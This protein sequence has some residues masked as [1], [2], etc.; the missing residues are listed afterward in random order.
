M[1]T[2]IAGIIAGVILF[3]WGFL[4]W[5]VLPIHKSSLRSLS[6][7]DAV[8]AALR[9]SSPVKGLYL[10]PAMPTDNTPAA[11]DAYIQKYK[12]GPTGIIIYDPDGSSPM[13]TGQMIIGFINSI[14]TGLLGAWLLSRSTAVS[15]SYIARVALFGVIGVLISLATHIVNWNW[16]NYPYDY[17]VGLVIDSVIGWLLAGLGAAAFLKTP[18]P[19]TVQ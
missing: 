6:N 2:I 1:K 14:L 9:A 18:S 19:S 3:I 17:T 8:I 12:A 15:S 16:L 10:F 4:A 5:A 7:E 11:E 13:M